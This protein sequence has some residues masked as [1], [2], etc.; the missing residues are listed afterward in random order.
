MKTLALALGLFALVATPAFAMP[1]QAARSVKPA[2]ESYLGSRFYTHKLNPLGTFGLTRFWGARG[3]LGRI[4]SG[5][6]DA[7]GK[8][9]VRTDE[10][11]IARILTGTGM[12]YGAA[13]ARAAEVIA[14][15]KA[16]KYEDGGK[17]YRFSRFMTSRIAQTVVGFVNK[18]GIGGLVVSGMERSIVARALAG[19]MADGKRML[20]SEQALLDV[21]LPE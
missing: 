13:K 7:G 17:M 18:M 11:S 12:S 10:K 20:N 5:T 2:S 14:N 16:G 3:L 8:G 21:I 1:S 9:I 6:V 19:R 15:S 4:K